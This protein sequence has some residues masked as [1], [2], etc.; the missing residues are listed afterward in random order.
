MLIDARSEMPDLAL[1]AGLGEEGG[2]EGAEE[3]E[4]DPGAELEDEPEDGGI[5][6]GTLPDK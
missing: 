5:E 4:G 1:V 6:T 2:D 3:E